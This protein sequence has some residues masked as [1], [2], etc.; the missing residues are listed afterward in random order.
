MMKFAE[1][2]SHIDELKAN[3][4]VNKTEYTATTAAQQEAGQPVS[5][6]R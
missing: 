6:Y 2:V 1:E 3:F 5:R 4:S